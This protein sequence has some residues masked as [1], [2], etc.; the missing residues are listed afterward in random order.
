MTASSADATV[1]NMGGRVA[2]HND[3][4]GDYTIV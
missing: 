2:F 4:F 3:R 1:T